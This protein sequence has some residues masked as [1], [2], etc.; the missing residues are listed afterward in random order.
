MS[1]VTVKMKMSP[2][3]TGK[4]WQKA[5]SLED[6]VAQLRRQLEQAEALLKASERRAS[7]ATE[8]LDAEAENHAKLRNSLHSGTWLLRKQA[9]AIEEMA[10]QPKRWEPGELFAYAQRLRQQ[11][12]EVEQMGGEHG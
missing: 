12:A 6:E 9:E 4:L 2:T 8:A 1:D 11:A 5:C 3:A 7:V 10:T